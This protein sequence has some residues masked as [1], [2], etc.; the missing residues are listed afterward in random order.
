MANLIVCC[1]GTW[2]SADNKTNGVPTP[3]NVVKI[4]AAIA[5][6]DGAGQLQKKYYHPGVGTEGGIINKVVGGGI[7]LGL[8]RNIK[9]GYRWLADAYSPGDNIF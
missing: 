5:E 4:H 6:K 2:A 1:D 8:V 3:T 7:G 9:S